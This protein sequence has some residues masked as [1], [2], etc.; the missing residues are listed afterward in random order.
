MR[1]FIITFYDGHYKVR[2]IPIDP[3]IE[4][5]VLMV[6]CSIHLFAFRSKRVEHDF[7]NVITYFSEP[8]LTKI[9]GHIRIRSR[10]DRDF[11]NR[12]GPDRIGTPDPVDRTGPDRIPDQDIDFF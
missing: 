12:T 5:C 8:K 9:E 10:P 7:K 11:R 4:L 6:L 3:Q 1:L 2:R